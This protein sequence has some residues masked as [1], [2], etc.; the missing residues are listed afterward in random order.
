MDK[1]RLLFTPETPLGQDVQSL[2]L[3][4]TE[5]LR[6]DEIR[7]KL[8]RE[9]GLH[10]T[11]ENLRELLGNTHVFSLLPGDRYILVGGERPS[12]KP[13]SSEKIHHQHLE[14]P[15]DSPLIVNLPFAQHDYVVFDLETTGTDPIQDH[16]IQI[17]ALKVSAGKP[18]A[19]RN[20]YVNPGNVIIPY[21]LKIK[22]GM[23]DNPAMERAVGQA[24]A[25]TFVLPEFLAF[26]GNLP[27]VAH[28]AR[29]DGRF[30]AADM[31]I[32][33]P[34]IPLVDNLELA[35][36]LHP[37]LTAHQ[38]SALAE[39]VGLPVNDLGVQWANLSLDS[40]FAAH[41]VSQETLHNAVTDVYV[42]YR[43]YDHFLQELNQ[44]GA[45]QELIFALLPEA[46][47]PEAVYTPLDLAIISRWSA[48]CDWTLKPAYASPPQAVPTPPT[49]LNDYLANRGYRPR[50]G[51]LDMQGLIVDAITK[52]QYAMIE[53]PTGTG[54][55]LAYL[56]A[57]VYA[58]LK[59]GRRVALSTAYRNLQDQLL[60]EI[61]DLQQ[62]GSV[63]FR[64]QLLKGV[65]NYLCWSQIARY[66][67]E[68][69][70]GSTQA[71]PTLTLAE[72][73]VLAYVM[74]WLPGSA[75][76]T[77]DELSFWLMEALPITRSVIHQLRASAACSPNLQPTCEH[78][79]MPS[80]YA[81][82]QQAEIIVINHALWLSE[83]LR[84]PPFACLVL[85]EAHNLEDV[86]TTALTQE[87]SAA[88]MENLL[89]KL[90]DPRTERGLLI[91]I[92]AGTHNPDTLRIATGALNAAHRVHVRVNDFGPFLVQFIR[93]CTQQVDPRYGASY[94]LE[95][96]PEKVHGPTWQQVDLA[97]RE[98]FGLHLK[99][100]LD[101]L[102]QLLESAR[103]ANDLAYR[104]AV[105]QDLETLIS[106]L[107]DQRSLAYELLR[108]ADQKFVY[109]IEVGPPLYPNA[110]PRDDHP[111]GWAIKAAPIDV[112]EAL[113]AFYNKLSSV[114]FTSATLALRGNDFSYFIDRLGVKD[115]LENRF[116]RKLPPALP[117][118]RNVLLG[119]TSYLTYAPL[120]H[121]MESFKQE[122]SNELKLF[123][124][125][126]DGR[127]LGLF[128]ARERMEFVAGQI[129]NDLSRSGIPLYVQS[130]DTS[131]RR[132]LEAFRERKEAVLFGLR[133]FWEGVDV[134]GE[135]LSFV[136]MEK[137]PFPLLIE[138]VHR[139]RAEYLTTLGKSEFDDYMLPLM[140]LQFKQG[141]GR[142][143]RREDDRGAVV[144][145][146]RRIHRKHYKADLL[147][148]LPG[149]L[150][151]DEDAE[152][153]RRR[154]YE[155]LA[156]T[157]PNLI[158]LDAKTELLSGLADDVLPG[159][160]S[161][162]EAF[163]IPGLVS[164]EE[165]PQWRS[166]L[167][168]AMQVLFGHNAFREIDGMPAQEMVIQNMLA[169]KDV[170]GVL[171]T[172]AGK[173]LTFQ[174]TALI[175]Q[176]VTLV[177]SP[178]IALM[179][180]Q[181]AGLNQRK[182]EVVGAIY[183]GQS[184]SE[185]DDVL[186][187]MQCGRARLVYVSPE[188]LRD[189]TLLAA[190]QNTQMIQVVVDEAHCVY[191]W[192]PSFR[193]DFLYL[194]RIF[195]ILGY[196][197]PVAALTATATPAMQD[198]IIT[199]LRLN[200]PACVIA[201][202]DRPELQ[203]IV[204]NTRSKYGAIRSKNDRFKQLLRI[205]R[206]A[207]RDRPSILVYVATTVEADQLSRRLRVAGYD[208]RAYHGKMAPEE[209]TSVQE[210]FM[211]D[212]INIVV[213]TKAFGMGI[214]KP[215]IRYVIHYNMPGDLESYF[216]EAGRAGRDRQTAYCILLYH[217]SDIHTQQFFIEN[218][219]PDEATINRVL[220]EIRT[221]SG[222]KLYLDPEEFQEKLGLEDVQ[223]RVAL[224]HLEAQGYLA[225]SADFSLT[226]A[227]TFQVSPEEA[228]DAWR[229]DN[230]PDIEF[231]TAL[232]RQAH[233]PAY[234]KV[235]VDILV[236]AQ[237]LK[238]TPD[239][240][241]QVLLQMSLRG[242]VVYHPWR[243]GF[244]LEKSSKL[245]QGTPLAAGALAAEQH[246]QEMLFKLQKMI[247]Y[248]EENT[249]C[250]RRLILEYF[251][252]TT[253]APCPS[254][255]SC[256]PEKEWPWSLL[257]QR[258][259]A[260]PDD[261]VDSAFVCLETIKWNL[262]RAR[263]Y[264]APYGTGTLLAILRGDSYWMAQGQTEPHMREWRLKQARS[265]PHWGVLTV[266]PSFEKVIDSTIER[267][268]SEGFVQRS[269]HT[270]NDGQSYQYL[271]LTEKGIAQLTSGRLLQWDLVQKS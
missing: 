77:A 128:T 134:P 132:L 160:E 78:C 172:G 47:T 68:G 66:L 100:L 109:W 166:R 251:G 85:D 232:F 264:G 137:L 259:V 263:K 35:L 27:L 176:G 40:N 96:P 190:L 22:L 238:V 178:L 1:P 14:K 260:T 56:T 15:S 29:F 194:P 83:P 23:V 162:L 189:P 30:I 253:E 79:P 63:A 221:L 187:R 108:V 212:H 135:T 67:D 210:M 154:F 223:L 84:M 80:A 179:K 252:Q 226:G 121:T 98:L 248:A 192:G 90:F 74:L 61:R 54:K 16:I 115:R 57:T 239:R 205:L 230:M 81:N 5:G 167:L 88:S 51:Q 130:P 64:S 215:D 245:R 144:L 73:F 97:H 123:L 156:A 152:R 26:V 246:R 2:L 11:P 82:A 34:T 214:D 216:Q 110:E 186:E 200:D 150:P 71:A 49:L 254:C 145:F 10:V 129:S 266:L 42:L 257:T 158:D 222:E 122:L 165:Y 168:E 163:Q 234:R 149:F 261:Y 241:D 206:A 111:D 242:E 93:R 95:A 60:G 141:F 224:H 229:M 138:P 117:Y 87:V 31:G 89:H 262:D 24:P 199:S 58:A 25:L 127:A 20:W 126:T 72:R 171:P 268:G 6:L 196:R 256:Q 201:P 116:V 140:L 161:R 102:G 9:K 44:P 17:A 92:R 198:A 169:G 114:T 267:L 101:I 217:K 188:R 94:R 119:L 175:R 41:H 218:G 193:P 180:D 52:D 203:L 13:S 250:R 32:D 103:A 43:V 37:N 106:D 228:L 107:A 86:A 197:P 33:W 105:L 233:W 191:M 177:F 133:S 255:D 159:L 62:L 208:A 7:R 174:L 124:R 213:C 99:D 136:L 28:N 112:G 271:D 240:I 236:L 247:Q 19:V 183:S 269:S 211:D 170:L 146:D 142:L 91:R 209:R 18:V 143:L 48:C 220:D 55:T 70:G 184:A 244:V 69:A 204:C 157:F 195:D 265:C 125:F 75:N 237:A 243:R 36:L 235:D 227:L 118:E 185:R 173:S 59:E 148:S 46:F 219:T 113:Q 45:I 231:L 3:P 153:S 8:R 182:I 270:F 258:D 53:A 207:D 39:A 12:G 65:G 164:A 38:L 155:K 104:Q 120:Q 147:N 202:I 50:P 76:G 151:R 139:A 131:R 21:T 4:Y 225:R 181:V 249:Q